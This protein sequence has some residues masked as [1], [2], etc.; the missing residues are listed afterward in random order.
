MGT[1]QEII[2]RLYELLTG[3]AIFGSRFYA[4]QVLLQLALFR[5]WEHNGHPVMKMLEQYPQMMSGE[6]IELLNRLLAQHTERSSRRSE[7]QELD[8]T[9]KSLGMMLINGLR[10]SEDM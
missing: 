2:D 3:L 7:F 5:Y 1:L 4:H 10:L 6:N 8:P 9:Y